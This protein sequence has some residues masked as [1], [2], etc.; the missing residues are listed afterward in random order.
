MNTAEIAEFLLKDG[1]LDAD[2]RVKAKQHAATIARAKI[3][4]AE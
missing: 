1:V 2:I 4:A 3:T